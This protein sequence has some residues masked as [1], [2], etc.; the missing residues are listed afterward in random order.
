[1]AVPWYSPLLPPQP[2]GGSC[3]FFLLSGC[4]WGERVL[5]LGDWSAARQE[6]KLQDQQVWCLVEENKAGPWL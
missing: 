4:S 2:L 5:T 3:E 6:G 1:M